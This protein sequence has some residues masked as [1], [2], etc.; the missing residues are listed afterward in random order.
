MLYVRVIQATSICL[1]LL[2]VIVG[3]LTQSVLFAATASPSAPYPA[4][5]PVAAPL[6]PFGGLP[7]PVPE[8]P[9]PVVFPPFP[10]ADLPPVATVPPPPDPPVAAQ[11]P[12]SLPP[13]DIEPPVPS[14]TPPVPTLPPEV[15][16]PTPPLAG[17]VPP[18]PLTSVVPE[19]AAQERVVRPKMSTRAVAWKSFIAENSL[20]R[21]KLGRAAADLSRRH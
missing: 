3:A 7:P 8:P 12:E 11:Q 18:E 16:T 2:G 15:P 1:A 10:P 5:P 4:R 20:M 14:I 19:L 17:A 21:E 13:V 6:P 9:P